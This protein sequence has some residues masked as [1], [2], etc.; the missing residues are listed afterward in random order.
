MLIL[1]C[2]N[3]AISL[4]EVSLN[5]TLFLGEYARPGQRVT[6]TCEA[7]DTSV[8][9]WYSDEYIGPGGDVIE[10]LNG[11][12]GNNQTRLGGNTVA[13]TVSVSTFSGITVIISQLHILT[14]DQ[15]P[16]SLV[17]CGIN[18]NGPRKAISFTTTGMKGP[19]PFAL[20]YIVPLKKVTQYS[21][22]F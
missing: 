22:K 15:I 19:I 2:T 17:T 9:E 8:L 5:H 20:L 12:R 13:T 14:S 3:S 18:G 1:L 21:G 6:F 7:R 11:G 4:Q 10:I 16:T